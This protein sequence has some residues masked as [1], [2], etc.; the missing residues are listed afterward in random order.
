MRIVLT[1]ANGQLGREL[2]RVLVGEDLILMDQPEY[3]LTNP[4]ITR[5]IAAQRPRV[6]IHAGACTDVEACERD[7]R[8]ARQVN[9]D[10]SRRVAE[11]AAEAAAELVYVS[12]D[13]V[14]DGGK[15]EPYTEADPVNPLNAYGRSKLQGEYEARAAC[16]NAL[17][18]RSSWLYSAH[19]KNFAK[20]ILDLAAAQTEIPVV[21][22]Q[23]GSPT[24]ARDL[25]GTIVELIRRRTAGVIHVAGEG[26][27]SWHEFAEAILREAGSA[28]R[29]V[30]ISTDQ[31]GRLAARP[32]YSVLS[33]DRLHDIGLRLPPWQ[34]GLKRFL[35]DRLSMADR[36]ETA[37]AGS[38]R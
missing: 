9:A 21:R 30:P 17:I 1:G 16:P 12:T 3:E 8:T 37:R 6:V 5:R 11:G 2:C 23:R 20:T 33:T 4:D 35:A 22:D 7:P 38:G 14:F 24:Y 27:A 25:A 26:E 29:V 34:D 10:G 36:A 15:T 19:G 28:S 31:A 13:Y 18:V 32:K